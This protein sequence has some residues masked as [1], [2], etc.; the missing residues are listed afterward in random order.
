MIGSS[1]K[2]SAL[3]LPLALLP[4]A[5]CSNGTQSAPPAGDAQGSASCTYATNQAEKP[6]K[7]VDPPNGSNVADKGS[8][9][10]SMKLD[11]K[12]VVLTLDREKAPC[13]TNSMV[14]L[15]KQGWYTDTACHRLTTQGIFVLQC[16]DPTGTGMG[17]P[18]YTF[19]DELT[20]AK[21]LKA[22]DEPGSVIYPK[23]TVAMA[24]A[25]PGTN[26]SQIFIV[27][28]DSPLPPAY[29]VFGTVDAAGMKQ[30]EA[31]AAQGLQADGVKPKAPA[32]ITDV[33][34]G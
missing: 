3:L 26:G 25:G 2:L 23:G 31:I 5:A 17:G 16:G 30:V 10:V 9:T 18:G 15:A 7:P 6:A 11:G 21:A 19:N 1:R 24:N 27:W 33:T 14:S 32:K 28:K 13:T 29:T 12:P 34:L 4:V 20:S 8:A 22:G